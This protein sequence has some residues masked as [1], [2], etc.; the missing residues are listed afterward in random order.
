VHAL[1][2]VA[3]FATASTIPTE[4][5]MKALND[6]LPPSIRVLE[7]TEA[8]PEFQARKSARAKTYRYR[9]HRGRF[10][11]RFWR[12]MCGITLSTGGVGDGCS[13]S[14]GCGRA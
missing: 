12:G 7:V 1:A 13:R 6:N 2:Q 4:N 5:W 14:R 10:V 9:M 3:S 11:R 8:A